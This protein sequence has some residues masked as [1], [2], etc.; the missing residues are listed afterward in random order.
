MRYLIGF[1]FYLDYV[2]IFEEDPSLEEK[3]KKSIKYSST[4]EPERLKK[5]K[6]DENDIKRLLSL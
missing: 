4:F 1:W 5:V 6:L 3:I 2:E